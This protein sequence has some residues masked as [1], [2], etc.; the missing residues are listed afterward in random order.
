MTAGLP[1]GSA[2]KLRDI[3]SRIDAHLKRMQADSKINGVLPGREIRPFWNAGAFVAGRFVGVRYVSFQ[4]ETNLTKA[5]ALA[6]LAALDSGQNVKH[7]A[8]KA[9][10]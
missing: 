9:H 3:A 6:Y 7:Y 10:R 4:G 8:L 2:P 5:D 1:K